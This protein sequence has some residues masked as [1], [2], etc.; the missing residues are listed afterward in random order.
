MRRGV[1]AMSGS[2]LQGCDA[3]HWM[4]NGVQQRARREE[5]GFVGGWEGHS[6]R[7]T[8]ATVAARHDIRPF[9]VLNPN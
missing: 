8:P 9:A 7:T 1:R 5:D 6:G 4:Q 3:L 2:S